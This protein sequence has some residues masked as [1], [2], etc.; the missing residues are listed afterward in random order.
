M[1][2]QMVSLLMIVALLLCSG[3]VQAA[4]LSKEERYVALQEELKRY[5]NDD[6]AM[7]LE[8]QV[9]GWS[10]LGHYE[11]SPCFLLYTQALLAAVPRFG[12]KDELNTIP[13]QVPMPGKFPPGC[14]F[15]DRCKYATAQCRFNAMPMVEFGE[16]RSYRCGL[17]VEQLR[18]VYGHEE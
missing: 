5:F 16:G 15:A 1:R 7:A 9:Q 11:M 8:D 6:D 3:T 18:E 12:V 2:K 4:I 13:G 17:S 14:R 10:E